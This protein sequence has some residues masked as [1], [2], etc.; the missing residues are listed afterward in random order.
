MGI[1]VVAAGNVVG[2][3]DFVVLVLVVVVVDFV[4]LVLVVVVDESTMSDF[5]NIH[6]KF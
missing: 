3:V 1:I 6:M 2:V 4:V 5:G